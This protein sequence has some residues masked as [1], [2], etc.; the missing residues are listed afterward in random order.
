MNTQSKVTSPSSGQACL[1]VLD[2]QLGVQPTANCLTI[3][4]HLLP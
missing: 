1:E 4:D 3:I 2:E